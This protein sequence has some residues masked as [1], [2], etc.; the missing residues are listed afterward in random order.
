MERHERVCTAPLVDN[1]MDVVIFRN[2]NISLGKVGD[3]SRDERATPIDIVR[4]LTGVAGENFEPAQAT[5]VIVNR[6][7]LPRL[8]DH[9]VERNDV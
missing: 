4:N 5:S 9:Q 7:G 8:P 1:L 3:P 6:A 2:N